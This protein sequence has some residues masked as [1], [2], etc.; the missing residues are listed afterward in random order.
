MRTLGTIRRGRSC[1]RVRSGSKRGH[2]RAHIPATGL[3]S[4]RNGPAAWAVAAW[5]GRAGVVVVVR[6]AAARAAVA[7]V[8]VMA[9]GG[10][11]VAKMGE[12]VMAA[13]GKGTRAARPVV[14][15]VKV[16]ARA[17][18]VLSAVAAVAT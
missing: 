7:A 5:V 13:A 12:A 4:R 15:A 9:A 11:A 16:V 17:A 8:A 10:A 6:M 18:A 3:G 14:A 2:T 1:T